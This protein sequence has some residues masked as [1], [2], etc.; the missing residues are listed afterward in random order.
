MTQRASILTRIHTDEGIVGRPTPPT[1]TRRCEQIVEVVRTEIEP[2]LIGQ[3]AFADRALLGA[4]LPGDVRPAARSPHRAGGARR[5]RHRDLGHD[6]PGV[7]TPAAPGVGRLPRPPPGQHHRRLLRPA[8]RRGAGG[9]R[10][11]RRVAR[12]WGSPAASS[13]SARDRTAATPARVARA[14]RSP[15]TTSSSRSTP[16]RATSSPMPSTCATGCA[17]SA[18]AGSRNRAA[19]RTTPAT[20]ARSALGGGIPVCAGQSE[21]SPEG[22]RDLMETGAIDV[23]NFDSSWAGGP[24]NWRRN[25][26]VA[27]IYGVELAHHEEPHVAVAP[28]R[29][30]AATG[31]TSRCST[32]TATRSGGT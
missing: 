22:C 11:G 1:R 30:P 27:H 21:Y 29:E 20:C 17:T 13:S 32:P 4:R 3:N 23:C 2:R 5:R 28:A 26:A 8:R 10:R 9:A 14:A 15:A 16:T 24:T 18:S 25:A 6:R 31:P 19:G 7:R 12:R